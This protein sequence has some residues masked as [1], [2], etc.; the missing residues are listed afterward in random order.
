MTSQCDA[1]FP[2]ELAI[3]MWF[4][5]QESPDEIDDLTPSLLAGVHPLPSGR[6]RRGPWLGYRD[7]PTQPP[8]FPPKERVN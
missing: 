3:A 2:E 1:T 5:T 6:D 4:R 8:P 7:H